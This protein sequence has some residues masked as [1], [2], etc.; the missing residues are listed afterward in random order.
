MQPLLEEIAGIADAHGSEPMAVAL[1]WCRSH[2]AM[3][4]AGMRRPAHAESAVD[5]LGWTLGDDERRRLDRLALASEAR[6]P[7]NPFQSE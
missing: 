5:A 6:M 3:P 2:G 4:I 1:N 7:A